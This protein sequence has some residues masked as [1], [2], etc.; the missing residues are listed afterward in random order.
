[1]EGETSSQD[2]LPS[3]CLHQAMASTQVHHDF[4]VHQSSSVD[5]SIAFLAG[6]AIEG[7]AWVPVWSAFLVFVLISYHVST[8]TETW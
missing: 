8:Q 5:A 1:M 6:N 7:V 2:I 3:S 4:M